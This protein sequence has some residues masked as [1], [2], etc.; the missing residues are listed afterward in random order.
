MTYFTEQ[1]VL[2]STPVTTVLNQVHAMMLDHPAWSHVENSVDGAYTIRTYMCDGA[3]NGTGYTFYVHLSSSAETSPIYV[4]A[5]EGWD[6]GTKKLIRG[7]MNPANYYTPDATYN[8]GTGDTAYAFTD[9]R[10]NP[11]TYFY[12]DQANFT[13]WVVLTATGLWVGGNRSPYQPAFAGLFDPFWDHPNEFPLI[14][15]PVGNS[16]TDGSGSFSR[17]PSETAQYAD[18]F[19]AYTFY[20]AESRYSPTLGAV[21]TEGTLYD[22]AYGTRLMALATTAAGNG[23]VR[24]VWRDLLMFAVTGGVAQGDTIDVD[25]VTYVCMMTYAS[26]GYFVNTEAP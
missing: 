15:G 7:C 12:C 10:W 26:V 18:M 2:D 11:Y 6:T 25:G 23:A 5:S 3:V 20:A 17:R 22:K 14:Q 4:R 24:G 21:P 9:A 13:Y 16:D 1:R 8:S 19:A